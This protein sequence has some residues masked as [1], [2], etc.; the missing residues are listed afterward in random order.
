MLAIAGHVG[1]DRAAPAMVVRAC[2]RPACWGPAG[3]TRS[4]PTCRP[5]SGSSVGYLMFSVGFRAAIQFTLVWLVAACTGS[6]PRGRCSRARRPSASG[7]GPGGGPRLA[8]GRHGRLVEEG[9]RARAAMGDAGR[10]RRAGRAR[11]GAHVLARGARRPAP[12][13]RRGARPRPLETRRAPP[14]PARARRARRA[15][16]VARSLSLGRRGG[17]SSPSARDRRVPRR[18]DAGRVRRDAAIAPVCRSR[19]WPC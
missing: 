9:R 3:R 19:R 14:P 17:R 6:P 18:L 8:R 4:G 12:D 15:R 7:R 1:A 16:P 5:R 10:Q 2:S 11:P 13:R